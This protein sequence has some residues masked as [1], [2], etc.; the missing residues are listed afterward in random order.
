MFAFTLDFFSEPVEPNRDN[1]NR[2]RSLEYLK[3]RQKVLEQ[4]IQILSV[5]LSKTRA[6]ENI[7]ADEQS[8][9]TDKIKLIAVKLSL[10]IAKE[11]ALLGQEQEMETILQPI[12]TTL[13]E[14]IPTFPIDTAWLQGQIVYIRNTL[15]PL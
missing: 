2:Y 14:N 15:K 6:V 8:L 5:R 7:V 1:E 13:I 10:N 3:D 12:T 11:K 4:Q 9:L